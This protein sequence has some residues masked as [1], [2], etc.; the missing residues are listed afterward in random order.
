MQTH[1]ANSFK[2]SLLDCDETYCRA[3]CKLTPS[4]CCWQI[5]AKTSFTGAETSSEISWK[6]PTKGCP[7]RSDRAATGDPLD[8]LYKELGV[9]CRELLET[10]HGDETA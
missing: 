3:S 9:R 6:A 10:L 2:S 5:S 7:A 4:D 1:V 8:T